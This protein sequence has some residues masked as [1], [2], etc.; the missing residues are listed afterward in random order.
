VIH[1]TFGKPFFRASPRWSAAIVSKLKDDAEL[2]DFFDDIVKRGKKRA[3][4]RKR[5]ANAPVVLGA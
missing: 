5:E 4:D 1:P 3:T 2:K